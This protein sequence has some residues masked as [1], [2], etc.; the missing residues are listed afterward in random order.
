MNFSEALHDMIN[1]FL[2]RRDSWREGHMFVVM[3]KGYPD[4][5]PINANTAEST[6]FEEGEVHIVHPYLMLCGGPHQSFTV[7]TPN[8]GDLFAQD[9]RLFPRQPEGKTAG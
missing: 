9:W 7:W 3:Q 6:G 5:I 4:G 2:V 1:G 8:T